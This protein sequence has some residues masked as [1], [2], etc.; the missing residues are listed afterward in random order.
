MNY[1]LF[2][3]LL[4]FSFIAKAQEGYPTPPK[5]ENRL[6]Y[7]QHNENKNTFVYDAIFAAKGVLDDD[8]PVDIYRILYDEDGQKKPLNPL[9]KKLAYGLEIKKIEKNVYQLTLVSYP[10]QKLTLKLDENKKPIVQTTLN[11]KLIT[12]NRVF[13]KQK[14]GTSGISVKLDYML[15]YGKDK[16]GKSVLEKV[17]L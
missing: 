6:F 1:F 2:I 12:L 7:I 17:V 5:S 8:N 16:H 14:K 9:Q 11:N 10:S 3:Y 4:L 15:F 13:L